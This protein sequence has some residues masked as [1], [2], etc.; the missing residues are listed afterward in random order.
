M[1]VLDEERVTSALGAVQGV[2]Y[3]TR[4]WPRSFERLPCLAVQQTGE[5]HYLYRSDRPYLDEVEMDVRIFCIRVQDADAIAP[6]VD[7]I[8]E[9]LDY[10]RVLYYPDDNAEVKMRLLR[11]RRW[12]G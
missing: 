1:L 4:G 10:T 11:Y 8:M 2:A 7:E 3:V 6:G 12:A 9:G 5:T